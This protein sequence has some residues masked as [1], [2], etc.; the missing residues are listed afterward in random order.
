MLKTQ[1][2]LFIYEFYLIEYHKIYYFAK[3]VMSKFLFLISKIWDVDTVFVGTVF[4]VYFR[5]V[6][7]L[8]D[9]FDVQT[10][11]ANEW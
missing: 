2:Q 5:R 6:P 1:A 11:T 9:H 10:K 8:Q 7:I 4:A 3:F